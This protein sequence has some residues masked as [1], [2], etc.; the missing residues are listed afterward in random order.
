MAV[1]GLPEPCR[2]HANH[3]CEMA[4][5][6]I[7]LSQHMDIEGEAIEVSFVALFS[8]VHQGL[9]QGLPIVGASGFLRNA[10]EHPDFHY[11][12]PNVDH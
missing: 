8:V 11:L 7:K 1:S 2:D 5:E 3:I 6:M 4:L 12:A 10:I 9:F